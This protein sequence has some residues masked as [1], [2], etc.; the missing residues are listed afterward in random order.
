MAGLFVFLLI[1]LVVFLCVRKYRKR[2]IS[3]DSSIIS[4][5]TAASKSAVS[6]DKSKLSTDNHDG[7]LTAIMKTR[8]VAGVSQ[9]SGHKAGTSPATGSAPKKQESSGEDYFKY[10]ATKMKVKSISD[11]KK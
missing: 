11:Y 10:L 4:Q 5:E 9:Y 7:P 8:K 1:V 6:Q 2:S 3:T